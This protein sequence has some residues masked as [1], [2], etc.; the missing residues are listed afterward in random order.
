MDP[1]NMAWDHI[2]DMWHRSGAAAWFVGILFLAGVVWLLNGYRE[3]N[4]AHSRRKPE[5]RDK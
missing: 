3:F 2:F 4:K 1:R 5:W